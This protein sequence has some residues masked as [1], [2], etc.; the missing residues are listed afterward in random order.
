MDADE[1]EECARAVCITKMCRSIVSKLIPK[2]ERV[3]KTW[4]DIPSVKRSAILG[5]ES[6]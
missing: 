3:G 5:E 2:E 6:I 4:R 1:L